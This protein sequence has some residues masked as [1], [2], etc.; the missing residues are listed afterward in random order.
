ML[1][2]PC[3]SGV[4]QLVLQTV[5]LQ[6][7]CD[8]PFSTHPPFYYTKFTHAEAQYQEHKIFNMLSVQFVSEIA[9]NAF[10][11]CSGTTN[12]LRIQDLNSYH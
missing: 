5:S 2:T 9:V 1:H 8:S 11:A 6:C 3:T 10:Q 12:S 7:G 4:T